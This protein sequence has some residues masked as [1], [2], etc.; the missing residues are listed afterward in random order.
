[1]KNN[2]YIYI[3][4]YMTTFKIKQSHVLQ[5]IWTYRICMTR[6]IRL[7][8]HLP[9][10]FAL[11]SK[12]KLNLHQAWEKKPPYKKLSFIK[13]YLKLRW[14]LR[15]WNLQRVVAMENKWK[16]TYHVEAFVYRWVVY[17][18]DDCYGPSALFTPPIHR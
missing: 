12:T 10:L 6:F 7:T 8:C 13:I 16:K 4:H 15:K 2:W 9:L 17:I 3:L 5:Q 18:P 11:V 1:M 14:D